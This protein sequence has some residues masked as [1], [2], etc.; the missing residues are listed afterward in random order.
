MSAPEPL[1]RAVFGVL[2]LASFAAFGIT[3]HLKHT[4]TAVQRFMM[5]PNFSPT[6]HHKQERISFLIK[7]NDEVTVSIVDADGEDVATLVNDLP[8][9]RY[10]KLSLR[11]NGR[12]GP[13]AHG[14]MAPRGEYRV[15]VSLRR[16]HRA[17]LSPR[18]FVLR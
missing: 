4:P 1:A 9:A 14:R 8:L 17:V 16:Q 2:V 6:G 5:T 18:S 3:Q 13:T 12:R 15:R 7:Q 10:T 11:W